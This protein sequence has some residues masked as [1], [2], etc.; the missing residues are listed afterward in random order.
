MVTKQDLDTAL[1]AHMQ[2]KTRLENAVTSGK[3]EFQPDVVKKDDVCDFGRWLYTRPSDVM[4][5]EHYKKVKVLHAEFHKVAGSILQL[6]LTGKT[7][8]AKK[9]L[10]TGGDYRHITG[11]LILAINTW[12]DALT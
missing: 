6:A 4:N 2:W 1:N 8:E 11:K 3:S 9:A 7:A 12:K 5:S 10:D